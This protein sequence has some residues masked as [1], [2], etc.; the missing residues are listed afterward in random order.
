MSINV[1]IVG[2]GKMGLPL[3]ARLIE[4]DFTV[5]GY[6]RHTMDDFVALGGIPVASCK[7]VAQHSDIV[8]TCLPNDQSLIEVVTEEEGLVAGAHSGLIVVEIS[9]LTLQAKERAYQELERVGVQMLDCPISGTPVM[10]A[11]GKTVFFGSGDKEAFEKVLPVFEAITSNNFYL[12]SF[13]AGS[14]MKCVANLLVAIHN[15]AA[16]EAMVV[17]TRAG[18]DPEMVMKVINPSI[19][20]SAAFASRAPMMAAKRYDPPLGSVGQ[21]KE[22]ILI[23]RELTS[24]LGVSTPLLDVAE[25]YYEGAIDAG[26]GNRDVAALYAFLSQ[27]LEGGS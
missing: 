18:L 27:D 21:V 5:Y 19:A 22:F 20:G 16:A 11:P 24:S 10:I 12:G 13:G 3:A 1:G 14:K 4:K 7:E 23:I 9:M 26:H 15:L 25:H 2:L 8:L 17:S 6:R